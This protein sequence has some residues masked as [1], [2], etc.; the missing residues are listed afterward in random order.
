MRILIASTF[1]P[2]IQGGGLFI[3]D[4]LLKA[5]TERGYQAEVLKLPFHSHYPEM[6]EQMLALRL[7]DLSDYADLLITIRTPS[8]L[9]KHPNKVVWFIHHHRGAYDLWGTV[10]QDIPDTCEGRALREAIIQADNV[11]LRECKKIFT[12]SKVVSTRLQ[13]YN[14]LASEVIYPPLMD[15]NLYHCL[16]YEDYIFYPSRVTSHKRQ[17][18][19]IEAMKFVQSNVKLVISG[20]PESPDYLAHLKKIILDNNLQEKVHLIE[21]WISS[22]KKINLFA[23]SLG[24]LYIPFEEDSYGY[25]SLEAYHSRKAVI[26]CSDSGGTLELI[27]DGVNGFI[28]AP[29]PGALAA[30]MDSLFL[31][32]QSAKA[33]GQTGYKK[34]S[35]MNISWENTI[36]KLLGKQN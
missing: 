28:T 13:N 14:N 34:L 10:Y 11:A 23:N 19:A 12:N 17:D 18:L 7:L 3:V 1:V 27:E 2:F 33:M 32:K 20:R 24:V 36:D 4:W 25:V 30:A 31:N 8:Y 9:I 21:E 16:D 5:F 15:A 26:T 6:L 22:E 35:L 29:N